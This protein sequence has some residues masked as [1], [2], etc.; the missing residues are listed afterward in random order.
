MF[1]AKTN[2]NIF[3]KCKIYKS[4]QNRAPQLFSIYSPLI[5]CKKF[6][7]TISQFWEK[8]STDEWRNAQKNKHTEEWTNEETNNEQ[9]NE[10]MN[11]QTKK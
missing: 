10:Q 4:E 3:K 8:L 11:K 5:S 9:T 2:D 1:L 7:K 6:K